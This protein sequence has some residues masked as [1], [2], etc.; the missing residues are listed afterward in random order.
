MALFKSQ[1]IKLTLLLFVLMQVAQAVFA[2]QNSNQPSNNI[3]ERFE[4]YHDRFQE[5]K[6]FIHTDKDKY[7]A[8]ESIWLK[9]YTVN[10]RNHKPDTLSTN[11][12]VKLFNTQGDLVSILLMRLQNGTSHGD[13][14]LPDSLSGGSYRLKAYTDWMKNFDDDFFFYKDI[15]VYSP[16][17]ENF[18]RR[19]DVLRNRRFNRK[20]ERTSEK[21]QF[22]VFPEGGYLVAG[23]E[24]KVAFKA[25]N[26][27]GEGANATGD[28][29]DN[30]G[31]KVLSFE[32]FHH[33]MGAFSFTP[34]PGKRYTAN[35]IFENGEDKRL[36]LPEA[37]TQGY[38]LTASQTDDL[39]KVKVLTNFD[40]QD[41]PGMERELFVMAHTRGQM[42]LREQVNLASQQYTIEMPVNQIPDGVFHITLFTSQGQPLAERLVFI[43]KGEINRAQVTSRQTEEDGRQMVNLN[44]ALEDNP[45]GG[46]YSLAFIDTE[47]TET[48]Y[49]QN[50][51]S[52]L[53]MFSDIG[54]RLPD[55][56]FYLSQDSE[57][58]TRAADLVMLTH[59]WRRFDWNDLMEE[60]YPEIVHGFPFGITISG[61]VM[62]IASSIDTGE[63]N[64][65]LAV[66]Q[67]G[68]SI[69]TTTT[70][71]KGNF[72]FPD[73]DFEGYF[74]ANITIEQRQ[75]RRAFRIDLESQQIGG[76]DYAANFNTRPLQV[77]ERG[78][79]WQRVPRPETLIKKQ[80]V[81]EPSRQRQSIYSN[82]DQVIYFDDIEELS[83]IEVLRSRVRGLR[84]SQGEIMLRG[85]TS[86]A[87]SNEPVFIIDDT[88]VDRA[89]FLSVS[90][91]DVQKLA[92]L[93]G[94]QSSILGSRGANGALLIYTRRGDTYGFDSYEYL[95]KGFHKPSETF[96]SSIHTK[97]FD[98]KGIDRT[99]YWNPNVKP[100]DNGV[101]DIAFPLDQKR[102]GRLILQ[103][104]DNTGRITFEELFI[105]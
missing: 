30:Q 27:L 68:V 84:I 11:L 85:R 104:I 13:I 4:T 24:N 40:Q 93:S 10:A 70:D 94:T 37:K 46:S 39:L 71:R 98:R 61:V 1:T 82:F 6:V 73:L 35:I 33:G 48:G 20:L 2:L 56:W 8:G 52:H 96:E 15:Q 55:P 80:D 76:I 64:L 74:T 92:V 79:D 67:N 3:L 66:F 58:A 87:M 57:K 26:S 38:L 9:A 28:L 53:L 72:A 43:N 18:I 59:G 29:V 34:E 14:T 50:I 63:R 95:M 47:A 105:E 31:R 69:F 41:H 51:A 42:V 101:I 19:R 75:Q 65:E 102:N 17:E 16:I 91:E 54:S 83:I 23:L 45:E 89:T 77:T 99:L 21:M 12:H 44:I 49:N 103:G 5:Q 100:D 88:I 62:P 22:A 7:M 25:A 81:F 36:R 86:I 78:D 32:T 60:K 97:L 90:T